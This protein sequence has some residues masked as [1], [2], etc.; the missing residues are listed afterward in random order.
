MELIVGSMQERM[1]TGAGVTAM[2]GRPHR[3]ID[4]MIDAQGVRGYFRP[5]GG[6]HRSMTSVEIPE[7]KTGTALVNRLMSG[8]GGRSW[9]GRAMNLPPCDPPC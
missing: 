7:Q 6:A 5:A 9:S 4:P 1:Q 2:A 8:A 3:E